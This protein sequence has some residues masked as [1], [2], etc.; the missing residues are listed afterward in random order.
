MQTLRS[1]LT[2]SYSI[3]S[4]IRPAVV[5]LPMPNACTQTIISRLNIIYYKVI[6]K[7]QHAFLKDA[8]KYGKQEDIK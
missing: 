6:S 1:A 3:I 2:Y 8:N 5:I 4:Q 7:K